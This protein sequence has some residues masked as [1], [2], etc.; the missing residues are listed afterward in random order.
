MEKLLKDSTFDTELTNIELT[1][2]S[3]FK[4]FVKSFLGKRKDD[5]YVPTENDLLNSYNSYNMGHRMS[6]KTR[7]LHS[8]L[9]LFP[10]NLEAVSYELDKRYHQGIDTAA[11]LLGRVMKR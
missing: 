11:V 6:P 3:S 7:F 9:D 8:H 4:A 5:N 2:W 1:A 10:E